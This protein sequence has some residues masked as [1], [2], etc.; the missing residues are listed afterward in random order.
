MADVTFT[1]NVINNGEVLLTGPWRHDTGAV[2]DLGG[3][4]ICILGQ[5]GPHA[6]SSITKNR[7]RPSCR[8]VKLLSN[9]SLMV[10]RPIQTPDKSGH[11][12]LRKLIR[13]EYNQ[14]R[15]GKIA[16]CGVKYGMEKHAYG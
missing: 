3:N 14:R 11:M 15:R 6:P 5:V 2:P 13:S 1:H 16:F 7:R 4:L 12:C 8:K 9:P 10:A